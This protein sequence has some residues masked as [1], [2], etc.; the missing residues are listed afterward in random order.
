MERENKSE[1]DGGKA[2]GRPES[3]VGERETGVWGGGGG[4]WGSCDTYV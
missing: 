3:E 1:R 2:R 4:R